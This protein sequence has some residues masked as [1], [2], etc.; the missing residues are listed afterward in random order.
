VEVASCVDVYVLRP[1]EIE[2]RDFTGGQA[3][4][5]VRE[6]LQAGAITV[7]DADEL[8]RRLLST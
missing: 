7:C 4:S 5:F 2:T 1:E 3:A 8:R 6:L